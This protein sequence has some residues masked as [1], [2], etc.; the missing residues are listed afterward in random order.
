M[1]GGV[2][3]LLAN[4]E[5]TQLHVLSAADIYKAQLDVVNAPWKPGKSQRPM[6]T[7]PTPVETNHVILANRSISQ[8]GL[9]TAEE[10]QEQTRR[11]MNIKDKFGLLKDVK[12][13]FFYNFIGEV[14]RVYDASDG[15]LSL[16]F[17]D[18]TANKSFYNYEWRGQ[19]T[20][21]V[22]RE[23]DEYGYTSK[24][25]RQDDWPG[26]FGKM[27]IQLTLHDPHAGFVREQVKVGQWLLLKNVRIRYGNNGSLEGVMHTDERIL[28]EIM[29]QSDE[30]ADNDERWKDAIRRRK[31]WWDKFKKQKQ[32]LHEDEAA[33]RRESKRGSDVPQRNLSKRR[34]KEKRAAALEKVAAA[35]ARI[36]EKLDLNQN[37]KEKHIISCIEAVARRANQFCSQMQ[38]P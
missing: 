23:G 7:R 6:W 17:A 19:R 1:Y 37:S 27:T 32:E 22:G 33:V 5:A 36:A 35:E 28:V 21:T 9:P 38:S 30:P 8:I 10:F 26:P 4:K 14:I 25:K 15:F 29:R 20:E 18:Y 24:T 34:R 11:S 12:P 13:D 31:E 2:P 16:Y 3:S